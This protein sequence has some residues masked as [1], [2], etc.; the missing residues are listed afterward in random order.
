VSWHP[1]V[2]AS[3]MRSVIAAADEL[4][5]AAGIARNG[6]SELNVAKQQVFSA[7]SSAR[8]AGFTV[9]EDLSVSFPPGASSVASVA[10]LSQAQAFAAEIRMAA[11][12]LV[13]LDQPVA[14]NIVAAAT[15]VSALNFPKSPPPGPRPGG[16][17]DTDAKALSV[18]DAGD[19]HKIVDPLPPGRQPFVKTVPNSAIARALFEELTANST[20]APPSSYPGESRIL[21][22]GTRISYR[23][24]SKSGGPTIDIVY[25]DQTQTKIHV[26]ELPKAPN[27]A[28]VPAPAPAPAPVAVPSLDPMPTP[29]LPNPLSGTPPVPPEDI[30]VI[31]VIGGIGIGILAGIGEFGKWV[32]SP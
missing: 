17:D 29:D 18:R 20:P 1:V 4:H 11:T 19:V 2:T 28:P 21:E 3:Q 25:P 10:R 8:A 5:A 23:E 24:G 14:T 16:P 26:E 32:F 27:P 9:G 22:D 12:L 13:T 7:V 6:A 30:G 15:G 31:G